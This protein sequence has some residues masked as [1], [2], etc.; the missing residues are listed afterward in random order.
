MKYYNF[1]RNWTKKIEPHLRNEELNRILVTDLNKYTTGRWDKEF[2]PG[3][4]PRDFES[5]DWG[6]DHRGKEPRYW[7]YVKHS[8]CHWV[9]NFNL[10]LS[11]LSEPKQLWRI[12]T[13]QKH[14]T[15]WDGETTLFDMNFSALDVDP[16]EAWELANH[17]GRILK[18]G[19]MRRCGYPEHFSVEMNKLKAER[20]K[21][22]GMAIDR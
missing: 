11:M 22:N 12:V 20:E 10:R 3:K 7:K 18:P 21:K 1:I 14:S 17:R 5:C 13:S 4:Y 15:V 8:A 16:D 6:W 19:K 9:V 2:P